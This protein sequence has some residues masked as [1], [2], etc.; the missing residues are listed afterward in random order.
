MGCSFV[1]LIETNAMYPLG[2]E[3]INLKKIRQ[4]NK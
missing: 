4:T 2:E 1:E 3:T